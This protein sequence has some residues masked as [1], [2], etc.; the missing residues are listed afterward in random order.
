MTIIVE[1][2]TL[3]TT[4]ISSTCNVVQS[5]RWHET[6]QK[7][8]RLSFCL[9]PQIYDPQ[10]T[11]PAEFLHFPFSCSFRGCK[12]SKNCKHPKFNCSRSNFIH[13]ML[14]SLKPPNFSLKSLF[15]FFVNIAKVTTAKYQISLVLY[16]VASR[17]MQ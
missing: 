11:S 8:A 16:F 1:Y 10:I 3:L 4:R 5:R 14:V 7:C 6:R 2:S 9:L 12:L 15:S 17:S 13:F